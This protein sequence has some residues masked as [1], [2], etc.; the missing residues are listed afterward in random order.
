MPVRR[1]IQERQNRECL[2]RAARAARLS[3]AADW[4]SPGLFGVEISMRRMV[5]DHTRPKLALL[6]S[7]FECCCLLFYFVSPGHMF[8][9][10]SHNR[11]VGTHKLAS[12]WQT[13]I[14]LMPDLLFCKSW[15]LSV[16]SVLPDR[17]LCFLSAQWHMTSGCLKKEKSSSTIVSILPRPA[18]QS[19]RRPATAD[20]KT[21]QQWK[22]S[23]L[24]THTHTLV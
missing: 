5:A 4:P 24:H 10:W 8:F 11:R 15:P 3:V 19:C 7:R 9:I 22:L 18:V 20:C 23:A 6:W 21:W 12:N 16:Q 14:T 13:C 17:S 1:Q 2:T